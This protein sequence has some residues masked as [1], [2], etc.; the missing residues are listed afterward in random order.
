MFSSPLCFF[1][2]LLACI[3]WGIYIQSRSYLLCGG[4]LFFLFFLV[5]TFKGSEVQG[6]HSFQPKLL[7]SYLKICWLP[8]TYRKLSY[9]PLCFFI[10]SCLLSFA[11]GERCFQFVP[12]SFVLSTVPLVFMKVLAPVMALL[13]LQGGPHRRLSEKPALKVLHRPD[14]HCVHATVSFLWS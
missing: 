13:Y 3:N 4:S 12:I 5:Q 9:T 8:K 7:L 1:F 14:T 10:L 6:W 2:F 11:V